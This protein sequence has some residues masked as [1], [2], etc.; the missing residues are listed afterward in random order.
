MR[1]VTLII[2]YF[3][4]LGC[5][6][7]DKPNSNAIPKSVHIP[8][9]TNNWYAQIFDY[10]SYLNK[11]DITNQLGLDVLETD[12]VSSEIRVWVLG[13]N[14][15]PQEI[16]LMKSKDTIWTISQINFYLNLG[17]GK[18]IVD[19]ISSR[20]ENKILSQEGFRSLNTQQI[21]ELPSQ[22]E[23]K[24]GGSYG[25]VDGY[26]V[27]IEMNNKTKYKYSFYMCPGFHIS[28]DSTFR[29]VQT[30][31]QKIDSLFYKSI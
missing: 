27:Q 2:F 21:W 23:M 8:D 29:F 20:I 18:L 24:N 28:K 4:F 30:F 22:S 6:N 19:S 25:C 15:N 10:P 12:T 7:S 9:T 17:Q 31:I 13:Y 3:I 1:S 14:Y 11:I 26:S 16:Y 5:K